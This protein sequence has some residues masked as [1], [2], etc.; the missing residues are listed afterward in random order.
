[1]AQLAGKID[2]YK[3]VEIVAAGSAY[4]DLPQPF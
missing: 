4:F 2:F 1:L 3:E